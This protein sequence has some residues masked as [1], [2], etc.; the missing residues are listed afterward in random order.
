MEPE[1]AQKA[2]IFEYYSKIANRLSVHRIISLQ[3]LSA[4][5]Y[6]FWALIQDMVE[7]ILL[8]PLKRRYADTGKEKTIIYQKV[9]KGVEVLNISVQVDEAAVK[10]TISIK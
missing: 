8:L 5:R 4:L 1:V 10:E 7:N 6:K 9:K 2:A 3:R